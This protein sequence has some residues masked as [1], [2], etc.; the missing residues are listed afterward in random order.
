M[1]NDQKSV[2]IFDQETGEIVDLSVDGLACDIRDVLLSMRRK[3]TQATVWSKL[4]EEQQ[5]D[6]IESCTTLADD[7]VSACVDVVAA[8]G[9]DV[10]HAKLDNFKIKD[11]A[12]TVTAKG[13]ADDGAVLALNHVGHKNIKIIVADDEQFKVTRTEVKVDLDQPE[14]FP[15]GD[16]DSDEPE[17][18]TSHLSDEQLYQAAVAIVMADNK[19][20]TSYIQRKLAISYSK[21]ASLVERMEEDRVISEA[22][23]LGKRTI[24]AEKVE[25]EPEAA[26]IDDET[27]ETIAEEMDRDSDDL[28]QQEEEAEEEEEEEELQLTDEE[29]E[30]QGRK[31]ALARQGVDDCPFDGGTSEYHHWRKG[32]DDASGKIEQLINEGSSAARDGLEE[33][34]CAYQD[35]PREFWLEG[36]NRA[37][38]LMEKTEQEQAED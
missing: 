30:A 14:M 21:A 2:E 26:P 16:D 31:T 27:P 13:A 5:R 34:S 32:Y 7:L 11:G 22:N 4:S 25:A 33:S 35:L 37:K 9:H 10:I 24:L 20:S 36:Y 23:H 38:A 6:E 29:I 3:Q 12:V 8:A 17:Q 1:G 19:C 15:E 28:D 18:D